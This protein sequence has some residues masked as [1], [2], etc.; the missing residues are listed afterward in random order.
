MTAINLNFNGAVGQPVLQASRGL[1]SVEAA[2]NVFTLSNP[3]PPTETIHWTPGDWLLSDGFLASTPNSTEMSAMAATPSNWSGYA[4]FSTWGQLESTL[5]NY[6]AGFAAV[7]A[8]LASLGAMSPARHFI[9]QV[10]LG[11]FFGG[12]TP[13]GGSVPTYLLTN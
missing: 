13:G 9:L 2:A 4:I 12:E 3:P 1:F 11:A 6:T 8:Y 10:N 7:D 5:G